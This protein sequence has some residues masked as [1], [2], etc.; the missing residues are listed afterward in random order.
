MTEEVSAWINGTAENHG[1]VM[2]A[3]VE[4]PD[5]EQAAAGVMMQCEVFY[6]NA[7][8]KYAPKLVLSWTGELTDLDSLSLDDTTIDIYPVVERNGDKS[9]NTLGIVAHGQARAGS[10]VTYR[11]VNGTTG[12]TE[13]QTSLIYPD[14]GLYADAFPTA[15]VYN[16]RLSNWQ[17]EVFT[18]LMPG[19]IY[20]VA[21]RASMDGETGAEA[22]SDTF[23]IYREGAFDLIPRIALHYGVDVN[24][25]MSDMQMQDALTK[26]GNLL[27]IRSPQSAAP[28]T[29]GELSGYYKSVI[30]GLLLGRA[31]NCEFGFEPV[32]LNTGNF[33]MEQTDAEIPDIGGSFALSRQYNSKGAGYAGSLGYGWSLAY[34]ERLG[35]LSDGTVLWLSGTGSVITFTKTAEGYEAP[36]GYDYVLAA[37]GDGFVLT[38]RET[39][40]KHLF[41]AYGM[42]T[43]TEDIYGNR[44]TL[45]YDMDYRLS[46]VTSPSGKTFTITPDGEGRIVSIGLPDGSCISY[47]YDEAGNL[48]AVTDGA[49]DK[50][51]YSYDAEHRM[52][53]WYDEKGNRVVQNAYDGEGRVTEQ[54]DA[55]GGKAALS[56]GDGSTTAV[57]ANGNTTVYYYDEQYRTT[58]I[59]Y[60]DGTTESRTYNGAGYL[61]SA[62]DRQGVAIAYTYDKKGNLLTEIRQDGTTRSYTYTEAGQPASATEYDGGV[63]AYEY[64]ERHRLTSV[65]DAEGGVVRYGYD[66]MNRLTSVTD[67]GGAVTSYTYEGA[68]AVGMRDAEGGLWSFGYDAM[69]RLTR[70]TDPEGNTS[71]KT[72]NAKGW[73]I[74][75]TDGAGNSTVYTFDPAGAVTSITDREGQKSVFTYDKMNR[76]LSAQ[77]PLGNILLYTYDANGNRL[78]ETDAEGNVTSYVYDA[79]NRLKE[80]TDP[81]GNVTAYTYDGGN[82]II[83]ITDRLHHTRLTA[84]M[85]P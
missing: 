52:T 10:T 77:D 30:D 80:K 58:G 62:T 41:N 59:S 28:Y 18:N 63:T 70:T 79:M 51:T 85:T 9:T 15:L 14:S 53:A 60:S 11:L 45:S 54:A 7:S 68:C 26:E 23:L 56:Y 39:L 73:C 37:E 31:E 25:V 82:R 78:T 16:R 61:S 48:A 38:D 12:E 29:A 22:V 5:R 35:E 74:R 67:A 69:N 66:E 43:A 36:A 33:Y 72:Y 17:S 4:A 55:E 75:E 76:M 21:A 6:N 2:K 83:S 50:R 71:T 49:G 44:T 27:F 42:L 46:A 84:P 24:M 65:T 64:D 81:E 20:Y 3:Q 57:D 40:V 47:A 13:A 34:D 32:N 19:Q 1:F 8:A